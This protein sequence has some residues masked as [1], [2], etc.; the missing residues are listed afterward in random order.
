MT[1]I[2]R[3]G[4][5]QARSAAIE[6]SGWGQPFRLIQL[7]NAGFWVFVVGMLLGVVH[8]LAFYE[9]GLS[10]YA[11]GL[12]VGALAFLPYTI[13]WLLLLS[14]HNR[15]TSLPPKLLLVAFLWG[16]IPATYWI[17]LQVNTAVLSI[18]GKLFGHA[19]TRD[20]APGFT[21]PITEELAKA[22]ALI[23]LIG[24][25]PK[26]V[27]SPY[28]GLMIGAF[29][30]LGL[31]VSEDLLYVFNAASNGFGAGQV[32]AALQIV[33]SRAGAGLV[34][35]VLFSAIFCA[36]LMWLIGRGEGKHR[37]RGLLLILGAMALHN[38]WDNTAAYG[39]RLAGT[40][41]FFLVMVILFVAG[42]VLLTI[43]FRLAAPQEQAWLRAILA[44]EAE[45]GLLTEAEVDAAAAGY[46]KRRAYRKAIHG[47]R[48]RKTAKHVL[49]AANDLAQELARSVGRDTEAVE[50]A[51]AEIERLRNG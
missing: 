14:Y 27:R 8:L 16:A 22:T 23:L 11:V 12:G 42:L 47:H 21:A 10:S 48:E 2:E 7:R 6:A 5:E 43:T 46:R 35:H 28:D 40:A 30:G 50:H 34:Q 15:Y 36:G 3:T 51:R 39:E 26:L 9:P 41:G 17:A 32:G 29:A 13:A 25:A 31:Q 18:Y 1:T 4:A 19:W 38:G 37:V 33:A 45:R 20:W 49:E 24:L 44:P